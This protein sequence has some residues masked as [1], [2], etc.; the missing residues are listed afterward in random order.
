MKT[1]KGLCDLSSLHDLRSIS[2]SRKSAKPQLST[3]AI[4]ELNMARNERDRLAKER[5]K[6]L[7]RKKQI[8]RRLPEIERDMYILKQQALKVIHSFRSKADM[9]EE[10]EKAKFGRGKIVLNY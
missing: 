1:L 10:I 6:L 5:E 3:T 7:K 2:R 9:P 8:D 4:L